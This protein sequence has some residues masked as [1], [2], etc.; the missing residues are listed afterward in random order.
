M[1]FATHDGSFHYDELLASAVLLKIYPDATI[2]RT[3]DQRL[4]E[5]ADI[6]YDVGSKFDPETRR[7]DHHQNTFTETYSPNYNI[8]LS[9]AG[10]IYKFY[11]DELLSLYDFFPTSPF[12]EEIKLKIYE[13]FFLSAD[14]IDNGVEIFGE[15]KPRTVQGMVG[16]FNSHVKK[17]PGSEKSE[18]TRFLEA[19]DLVQSDFS[20]YMD[21]VLYDYVF[22]Y[23]DIYDDVLKNEGDIFVTE[24]PVI[25]EI[26]YEIDKKFNKGIKFIVCKSTNEWRILTLPL[27]KHKFA[28]KYPLHKNWRGFRELELS[29]IADIP[30]CVFVHGSGFTGS[31]RTKEGAIEMCKRSLIE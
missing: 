19:L 4:I 25:R 12:Y 7:F 16:C 28:I 8:K 5:E 10:L 27:E 13:E 31:N 15:I 20:R 21:H 22:S 6:V 2:I 29:K 17:A 30:D 3:R 9:S 18:N 11:A 14:A 1:K 24:K 26:V 23:S